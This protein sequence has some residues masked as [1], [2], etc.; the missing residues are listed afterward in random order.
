VKQPSGL[1]LSRI[2]ESPYSLVVCEK[3]SV[4]LRIAQALGT[5]SFAKITG[6]EKDLGS[7]EK[8]KSRFP[9]PVFLAI[10]QNG[11][12]FVVCSA[13]G[14]L[15]G[16]V[17][18]NGN[19]SLYPVF[20][21][22]W[23]PILRKRSGRGQKTT[24]TSVQ[25]IK[26]IFSLSQKATK[27]IHACDY[28]QEG[29]V[30]GYNI[31]EY[32]CNNKYE[33]SLRA[34]FS[35]LT[36][37]EIRNSFDNLLPPSKTLAEAGRTRHL[38][39]FIYG[40]NLSRALTQAFK[41]SN[42]RKK[43]HN[44]SIGRVQGPTLAFVVD[45]EL[46]IRDHIPVPYWTINAEFEKDGHIIKAHYYR[47]KIET[48]SEATSI[49]YDC[50][51]HDGKVTEIRNQRNTLFAPHPFNLGDLQK[52]AYRVFKFSPSY[53]LSIAEK[54]YISAIISYPRTSSQRLPSSIN[55]RKIMSDLS[56]I[57]ASPSPEYI[58]KSNSRS[59]SNKH[60]VNGTYTQ[61]I[62]DLLS[63][64]NHLSPNEGNKT[65][66]AHPSI[67][68]TGEK[69]KGKLNT[70]EFKLF[71]LVVRRFLAT[72][73][74]P[75]ISRHTMVTISV[76][77]EHFFEADTRMIID[78]GWMHYYKPYISNTF[79]SGSQS[80]LQNLQRDDA[81]KNHGAT[82]TD[83]FT[84]PPSRF[85]QSSL[86]EEMESKQI[87]TKATR[88]EIIST[89]FKRNYISPVSNVRSSKDTSS[90]K[91]YDGSGSGIEATD[92]G[93]EI[94]QSMRQYIPNVVSI[95]LTRSTEELL[96]GIALG[97][98][99]SDPIIKHAKAIL[100]EAIIPFKEK[101]IEIGNRITDAINVTNNKQQTI[102][103]TCPICGTGSLKII[104]SKKTMRRF[105]GCSNYKS[106]LCKAA[107]PL[108]QSGSIRFAGEI[109]SSCRWPVLEN[110]F[111]RGVGSRW[112]FCINLNCPSKKK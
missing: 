12:A 92:L 94:L 19:R 76:V 67:Y 78:Q 68:P 110:A 60:P 48:L 97:N 93:I 36:D 83:K 40:V 59:K 9:L 3:P 85:N 13:L 100:K 96:E 73:G 104:K 57:V 89:L 34:K 75:A 10:S 4:A 16:L 66:P 26:S 8:R 109:C 106:G 25:I 52:E 103:G 71:D 99:T 53:T 44:L 11:S 31:L 58:V 54:L 70:S 23:T 45:R 42:N 2:P 50:S 35:T 108:P 55:F 17:D 27:F 18:L 61:I 41:N 6:L 63:N 91:Q 65:D 69:P 88:S 105:V 24:V 22:K 87:G 86:L 15:Y 39:D 81:L 46:S 82:M 20:E 72:F 79:Y 30:I 14:H 98:D 101:E 29:E 80:K 5:S 74:Q 28:D 84:Q 112:K 111:S 64:S 43:Y 49:V 77:G 95:E 62:T 1:S 38:I 7:A 33:I 102:L 47:Q 107:V 21:V 51:S 56:K 90:S 32:A 37:Q